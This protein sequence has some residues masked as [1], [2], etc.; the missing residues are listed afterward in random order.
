MFFNSSYTKLIIRRVI[1]TAF[2]K[3][4]NNAWRIF[5]LLWKKCARGKRKWF[6]ILKHE[7][8]TR[9]PNVFQDIRW[10]IF[11]PNLTAHHGILCKKNTSVSIWNQKNL[12]TMKWQQIHHFS[13]SEKCIHESFRNLN[14]KYHVGFFW[15]DRTRVLKCVIMKQGVRAGT[16]FF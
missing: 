7:Y 13:K 16:G 3:K 6:D 9:A 8:V 5:S 14:G 11:I 4:C 12:F 2:L 10:R 1:T 15:I